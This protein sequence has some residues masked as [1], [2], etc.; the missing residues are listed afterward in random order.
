MGR[1]IVGTRGFGRGNPSTGKIGDIGNLRRMQGD[2]FEVCVEGLQDR[3][4]HRGVKR[5]RS[6]Q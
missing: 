6:V 3:I 2:L 5:V 4:H 1:P